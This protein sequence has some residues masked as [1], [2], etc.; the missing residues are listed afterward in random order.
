MQIANIFAIII[1]V[2]QD[3]VK[4]TWSWTS[5]VDLTVIL[6]LHFNTS[7]FTAVDTKESNL[8]MAQSHF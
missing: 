7:E 2:I 4:E 8:N 6:I 5:W 1:Q 3:E